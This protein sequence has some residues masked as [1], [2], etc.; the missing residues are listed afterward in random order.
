[1]P[2]HLITGAGSG[3]GAALADVLHARGDDLVLL[4][5]SQERADELAKKYAGAQTVVADLDRRRLAGR[6]S[7][8][9]T[10]S[11]PSSTP[12]ASSSSARWPS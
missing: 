9:R 3:I 11:T 12:P 1:M 10:A 7:S 4:A 2:T 6:R 8:S 5:R